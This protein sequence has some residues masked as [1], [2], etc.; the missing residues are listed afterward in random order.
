[1]QQEACVHQSP[2]LRHSPVYLHHTPSQHPLHHSTTPSTTLHHS[3]TPSATYSTIP[4][5][6]LSA[7][8]HSK[9]LLCPPS[10]TPHQHHPLNHTPS[11]GDDIW[12]LLGAVVIVPR[13]NVCRARSAGNEMVTLLVVFQHLVSSRTAFSARLCSTMDA[14]V[15]LRM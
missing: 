4:T 10:D 13:M 11:K 1:M 14:K 3:T 6:K 5:A 15:F 8:R 2:F 7:P 9:P 12:K